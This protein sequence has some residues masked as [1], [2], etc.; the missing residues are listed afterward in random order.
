MQVLLLMLIC[1]FV[2][3]MI[4]IH[5]KAAQISTAA[6][7][8]TPTQTSASLHPVIEV[9]KEKQKKTPSVVNAT[10]HHHN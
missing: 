10:T 9:T 8:L 5:F 1:P 4:N 3:C 2:V 7:P 6:S